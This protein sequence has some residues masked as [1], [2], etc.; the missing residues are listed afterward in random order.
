MIK[1]SVYIVTMNEEKRLPL[2]LDSVK[3]LADEIV[4]V[5]SGSTDRTEEIG[6]EYVTAVLSDK[7]EYLGHHTGKT[8]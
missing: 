2:V 3:D 1:L 6:H 4:V 5:D 7:F 8:S